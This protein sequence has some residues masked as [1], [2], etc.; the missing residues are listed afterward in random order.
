[1]II[2]REFVHGEIVPV[3]VA[4]QFLE[5]CGA[6][7]KIYAGCRLVGADRVRIGCSSQ[8]DEG[9]WIFAGEG[10]T[11]GDH[12]HLAFGSSISGGGHCV[13]GDFA[14]IGA[15]VRLVTGTDL[16][17]GKGLTNPTVPEE[18]RSVARSFVEVG[19]HA[20]IFTNS[21]VLPGVKIGEGT[22]VSAGSVVHHDLKPWT[23]Y[24]GNPLVQVGERPKE[25]LLEMAA[26]CRKGPPPQ[27]NQK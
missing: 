6:G 21:V 24:A 13:I 20:V 19:A 11:M 15:G 27:N 18:L 23:I 1:M 2:P 4:S 8:I 9:V 5:A 3:E 14:G 17:D 26:I 7:T 25:N 12:V 16:I 22:V 10:V